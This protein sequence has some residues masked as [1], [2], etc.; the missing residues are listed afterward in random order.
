[1]VKIKAD[2]S[3]IATGGCDSLSLLVETK[4]SIIYHLRKEVTMTEKTEPVYLTRDIDKYCRIY[5]GL[6]IL[7]IAGYI[8]FKINKLTS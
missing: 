5:T 2:G 1:V 8:F 6:S 3:A 7:A 4:D